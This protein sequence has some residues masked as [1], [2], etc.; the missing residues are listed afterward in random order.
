MWTSFLHILIHNKNYAWLAIAVH[1]TKRRPCISGFHVAE[2]N[3][4]SGE[5]IPGH[6]TAM[7]YQAASSGKTGT[8]LRLLDKE[9]P[10]QRI[11]VPPVRDPYKRTALNQIIALLTVRRYSGMVNYIQPIAWQGIL[12]AKCFICP[13]DAA[14][15]RAPILAFC[16]TFRWAI[17]PDRF[18]PKL[19]STS[20]GSCWFQ[21]PFDQ[22]DIILFL[23]SLPSLYFCCCF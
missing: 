11:L 18:M 13:L 10:I 7:G 14:S 4:S 21:P 15:V 8:N 12:F 23:H 9:M 20:R 5:I 3:L 19:E 16:Q 1:I 6:G 22:W 2:R 17:I